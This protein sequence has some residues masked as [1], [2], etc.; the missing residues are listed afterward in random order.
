MKERVHSRQTYNVRLRQFYTRSSWR[1]DTACFICV[2]FGALGKTH[3]ASD[4]TTTGDIWCLRH[5]GFYRRCLSTPRRK[6][7]R[8]R[9]I[10]LRTVCRE[11]T[12]T[13]T[14]REIVVAVRGRNWDA[15]C[16]IGSLRT[17]WHWRHI[18][19]RR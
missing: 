7:I 9:R 19:C 3:N 15:C 5:R 18:Y 14:Y 13:R 1:S 11:G 10:L 4:K 12:S 2:S 6:I 17:M 8:G 16:R